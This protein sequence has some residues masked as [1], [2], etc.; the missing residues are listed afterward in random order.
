M[1]KT[2]LWLELGIP[3]LQLPHH[4]WT[5]CLLMQDHLGW[6]HQAQQV[7]HPRVVWIN[8]LHLDMAL[9][10]PRTNFHGGTGI[11]V[12]RQVLDQ[13]ASRIHELAC[14][15]VCILYFACTPFSGRVQYETHS[16]CTII[17][18]PSTT[19]F[20]IQGNSLNVTSEVD[21]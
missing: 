17:C 4:L 16:T 10:P 18:L 21:C 6:S 1:K 13:P 3:P 8:L 12:C 2:N 11:L 5:V 9:E 7:A 15:S 14:V 19:C 20:S